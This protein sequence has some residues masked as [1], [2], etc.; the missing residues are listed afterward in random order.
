MEIP[1][2]VMVMQRCRDQGRAVGW[3]DPRSTIHA[4][5]LESHFRLAQNALHNSTHIPYFNCIIT[6]N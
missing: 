5:F 3:Y 1:I 6:Q 2:R 4:R